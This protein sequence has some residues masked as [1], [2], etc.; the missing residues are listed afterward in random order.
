MYA[1]RPAEAA[2]KAEA[3]P[4][5]YKPHLEAKYVKPLKTSEIATPKL[6]QLT[7]YYLL[8]LNGLNVMSLVEE[9]NKAEAELFKLPVLSEERSVKQP[10]KYKN[11]TPNHAPLIVNSLNGL[12]GALAVNLVETERA[13][14]NEELLLNLNSEVK[15]V[16]Y[17]NKT[18]FATLNHALSTVLL[19][20]GLNGK[21]A[22]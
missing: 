3:E 16:M 4:S 15:L 22:V 20:L 12:L 11:A 2:N 9:A 10:L 21:Y 1:T 7:V 17:Y 14:E 19:V 6:V 13:T 5:P 8:G 18:V